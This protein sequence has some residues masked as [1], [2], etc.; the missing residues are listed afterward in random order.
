MKKKILIGLGAVIGVLVLVVVGALVLIDPEKL[1]NEKKDELLKD[2]SARIGREVTA[3]KVS[4]SIG[5]QLKARVEQVQ[6]AGLPGKQPALY[7][8]AVDVRFSLARALLSFG[9]DLHVERF[10]VQG[11]QLRAARDAE[12]RWDFQDIPRRSPT[13]PSWPAPASPRSSWMTACSSSMTRCSAG[14]CRRTTST[15]RPATW[16][17]AIP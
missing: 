12:A 16:C 8:G 10:R 6:V 1:V 11:L 9:R 7:L 15:S 3:G 14:P 2:V 4:A 13:P 5:S 17:S